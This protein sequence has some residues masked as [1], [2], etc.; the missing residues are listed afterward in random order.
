MLV[1][2]LLVL[3]GTWQMPEQNI[4]IH[5]CIYIIYIYIYIYTYIYVTT[6][7]ILIAVRNEIDSINSLVFHNW[8]ISVYIYIQIVYIY[9]HIYID[10]KKLQ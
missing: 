2:N 4:Y 1:R 9:I 8:F 10:I 5:I 7:D 6:D 3:E